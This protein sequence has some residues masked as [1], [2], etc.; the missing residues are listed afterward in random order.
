MRYNRY[1]V[2]MLRRLPVLAALAGV[3]ALTQLG[4]A[5]GA[6]SGANG[7]IAYTCGANIC[8]VNADGTGEQQIVTG[9]T[10]PSWAAGGAKI[11]FITATTGI[12]VATYANG[13]VSNAQPVSGVTGVTDVALSPDGT[14]VAYVINGQLFLNNTAGTSSQ[15]QTNATGFVKEVS[16]SPD[17]SELAYASGTTGVG[18]FEICVLDVGTGAGPCLGFPANGASDRHPNWSPDGFTIVFD[19][20]RGGVAQPTLWTVDSNFFSAASQLGGSSN[21][22]TGTDPAYSPD[23]TKIVYVNSTASLS[24]VTS[25]GG[26]QTA[27]SNTTGGTQPD[28]QPL[29]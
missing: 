16:W 29:P 14:T 9:G 6:Y 22:V 27:I 26:S 4:G 23:G 28:W 15:P 24:T 20:T 1:N 17:G 21:S 13:T 5:I 7:V 3:V 19:S 10:Q 18:P 25:S 8:Q 2:R 11:A 12:D